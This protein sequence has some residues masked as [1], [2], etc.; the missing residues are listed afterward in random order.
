MDLPDDCG[1]RMRLSLHTYLLVTLGFI[2]VAPVLLFGGLRVQRL[3]ALTIAQSQRET[4]LGAEA[5]ARE[6]GQLMQGHTDAVEGLAWQV[7]AT[8]SMDAALLQQI[9]T[10]QHRAANRLGN[11]WVA[12]AAGTSLAADPPFDATGRANAGTDYSDRDYYKKVSSTNTTAYSRAQLGRT[13]RRP[14]LQ[15]AVPIR[16][17]SGAFIGFAQGAIDLAELQSLAESVVARSP[18]LR[19][20][21]LDSEGRILAHPNELARSTMQDLSSVPLYH[22]STPDAPEVRI[23]SDEDGLPVRAAVA[24]VTFGGLNWIVVVSRTEAEIQAHAAQAQRETLI[25]AGIA[26]LAG[27]VLAGALASLLARPIGRLAAVAVAVGLGD[28]SNLPPSRR[29]WLPREVDVLLDA[30]REMV[31]QL[32]DRTRELEHQALRDALTGLPNRLLLHERLK[33]LL[34][35]ARRARTPL[36]LLV[37]DLDRFKEVN[38][39]LGHH[40]GDLVLREVATRFQSALRQSDTVARLGGDEFAV[41]LP[42]ADERGATQTAKK[43]LHSL[44][45]PLNL[46]GQLVDIGGSI[47]IALFPDHGQ[48]ADTLLRQ[49]DVAMYAAKGNAIG[50]ACY[51]SDQD[52]DRRARLALV[53]ELRNALNRDELILHYQPIV[54]VATGR[55]LGVEALARWP[56]P[57]LGL[58]PPDQ[59]IPLAE[60]TGLIK[61][62]SLWVLNTAIRQCHAWQAAGIRLPVAVNLSMRNLSDLELPDAIA[63]MLATWGVPAELLGVEVTE[64]SLMNDADRSLQVLTR[65]RAMGVQIAIDDFGTGYSSLA[66]LSR[67]PVSQIKIDRSFVGDMV[68]ERRNLTIVRSTVELAHNLGLAVVAEGVEDRSTWD[69]LATL[70]CDIAQGYYLSRPMP[71]ADVMHWIN[72]SAWSLHQTQADEGPHSPESDAESLAA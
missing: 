54:E 65:L 67:L 69:L 13:T 34:D 5:L 21:I 32:R 56:H 1:A 52:T 53:G 24:S 37:I 12:N 4:V 19:P 31:I 22:P 46:A 23:E 71:A 61:P 68:V 72:T 8:G 70:G 66:Y 28:L 33:L 29:V 64:S 57:E 35:T 43:L 14:N 42:G 59:F 51:A 10:A 58:V 45:E 55:V 2:A 15:I 50:H 11:M 18:G 62:L 36:A 27:L 16:D 38:D 47:G 26:L 6:V 48:D 40:Q 30:V 63:H 3:E 60:Q 44:D 20:V 9:A 25:T 39:T 17:A 7:E 41:L 49:A